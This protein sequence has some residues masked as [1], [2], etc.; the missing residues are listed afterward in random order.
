[1][2]PLVRHLARLAADLVAQAVH[3]RRASV[4]LVVVLGGLVAA[5]VAFVNLAGPLVVYPFL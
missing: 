1:M 5:V 3:T 2:T 4:G